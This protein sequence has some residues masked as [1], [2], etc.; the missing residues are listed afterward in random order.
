MILRPRAVRVV[1]IFGLAMAAVIWALRSSGDIG[2]PLE[3][4]VVVHANW[5][6]QRTSL[7]EAY[8]DADVAVIAIPVK[9]QSYKMHEAIFT[10]YSL[11]ILRVLKGTPVPTDIAVSLTGGEWQGVS[12]QVEG[13]RMLE[14]GSPYLFLLKKRFPGDVA[15]HQYTP[16]GGYQGIIKLKQEGEGGAVKWSAVSFNPENQLEKKVQG[17]DILS[18]LGVEN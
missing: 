11:R 4:R 7:Q 2:P 18:Y 6:D 17:S 16:I 3:R 1:I 8:N 13:Q 14:L 15:N 12:Y 5:V 9:S 10:D